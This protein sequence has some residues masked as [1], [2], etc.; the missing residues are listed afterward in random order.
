MS[1]GHVFCTC[2]RAQEIWAM[3]NLIPLNQNFPFNSFLD[4]LWFAVMIAKWEQAKV[5]KV[6]MISWKLWSNRNEVRNGGVKKTGQAVIHGA[7]DYLVEYQ[8]SQAGEIMQKTKCPTSWTPPPLNA[9][10]INVDGAVFAAN[11]SA[12]VGILNR[13]E[14]GRLIGVGSKKLQ[15]PL[16]AIE[17]E[18]KAIELRLQSAKDKLIQDFVLESDSQILIN[19]LKEVS[20][21]PTAVAALVYGS[22][23]TSHEFRKVVFPH[24]GRQG[25]RSTH[26]FISQTCT[27]HY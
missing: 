11:K 6:I 18:A 25:N 20:P 14:G 26:S 19:A 1:S 27:T 4:F 15:L 9:Y 16:G 17:V 22:L 2:P 23:S 13:D 5:E 8:S 21:P 10:K 3:T 7:L 24:V 12:G